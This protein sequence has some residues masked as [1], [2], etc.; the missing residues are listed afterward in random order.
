MYT[1]NAAIYSQRS[2][3]GDLAI[4]DTPIIWTEGKFP[5]KIIYF[6]DV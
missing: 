2:P 1:V 4:T 6:T 5:A 3:C